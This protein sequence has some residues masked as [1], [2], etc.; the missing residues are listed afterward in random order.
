MDQ[1]TATIIAAIVSALSALIAARFNDIVDMFRSSRKIKGVWDGEIYLLEKEYLIDGF[2]PETGT[3]VGEYVAELKQR[4]KKIKGTMSMTSTIEGGVLYTH[5][6]TGYVK[7]SYF[8]YTLFTT[9][10]EAFRISTALL[11]IAPNGITM[12]GYFVAN[13]ST[14]SKKKT[15]VGYTVMHKRR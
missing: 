11:A 1:A 13:P 10:E 2:F 6:Y 9:G 3:P 5:H 15:S 12:A 14:R 7:E 4:G 8:I